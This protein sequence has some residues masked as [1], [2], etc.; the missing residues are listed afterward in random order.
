MKYKWI[1]GENRNQEYYEARIGHD[2]LC[3]YRNKRDKDHIIWMGQIE[4]SE[5]PLSPILFDKEKND[6][7]RKLQ[8]LSPDAHI[9]DLK[10]VSVL[11]CKSPTEMIKKTEKAYAEGIREL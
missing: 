4:S 8:G 5:S 3:V 1:Y 10:R 11:H 6:K 9:S 7:Q 2:V